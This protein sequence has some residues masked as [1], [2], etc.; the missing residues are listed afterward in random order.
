MLFS[1]GAEKE[2]KIAEDGT[3][4][5]PPISPQIENEE[6]I[7][8]PSIEESQ[9]PDI[10]SSKYNKLNELEESVIQAMDLA[11][12]AKKSA[13]KAKQ[14]SVG[15]FHGKTEA[16]ELLQDAAA[17]LAN[18]QISAAEAQKLL[19]E[20]QAELTKI[21][22]YLFGLGASSLAMN[23]CVVREL[24]LRLKGA[25]EKDISDLAKQELNNVILQLKAQEDLMLR[26]QK[27]ERH[28]HEQEI[29]LREHD[30]QLDDLTGQDEEQDRLIADLSE[31]DEEQDRILAEHTKK[32]QEHDQRIT[33]LTEQD[34]EQDRSIADL[35]EQ[36]E[37]QDRILA[38][39][40]QKDREHD[41]RITELTGQDEAQDRILAEHS[42]KDEEH[43][44]RLADLSDALLRQE[45][46]LDMQAQTISALEDQIQAMTT[47][48]EAID[49]TMAGK[50]GK[51]FGWF[52]LISGL[53]GAVLAFVH[54][55]L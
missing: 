6:K 32:D 19:F 8:L 29:H 24:E 55:F 7:K 17:G 11:D 27:T 21:T 34:E 40:T 2:I 54:Y 47:R 49:G 39:H 20:Y 41:Q 9:V 46:A 22:K 52:A 50:A 43:D 37:E 31:Q 12:E 13:G 36:D 45:K 53:V 14:V 10:I 15:W 3:G 23:R 42:K 30:R 1:E 51:I 16:I 26:Q 28:V 35:Q 44:Q 25:S 5:E 33:E 18:A 38:E 4:G 48:I